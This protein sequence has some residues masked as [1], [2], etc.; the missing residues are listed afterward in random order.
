MIP[1]LALICCLFPLGIPARSCHKCYRK[2]HMERNQNSSFITPTDVNSHCYNPSK[3]RTCR[4]NGVNY[5]ITRNL[6]KS[7][8]RFGIECRKG[9]RWICFKFNLEDGVQ[10]LVKK[11]IIN[12]KVKP[13][14]QFNSV[15][16]PNYLLSHITRLQAV[17]E[18]IANGA[19]QALDLISSQLS[20][21]KTVGY[22]NKLALD[23]LLAREGGVCGK[24]N[25]S[26]C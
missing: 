8:N 11:Q 12:K 22:Q 13:A 21:P 26:D 7:G 23:Y 2:H 3:L 18:M 17:I 10:D 25:I 20:Q 1:F 19:T 15:L 14:Q 6:G 5:W 16:T 24:F 9:E 4:Q